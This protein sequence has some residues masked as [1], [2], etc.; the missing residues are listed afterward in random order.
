MF[1]RLFWFFTGAA[2]G[3]WATTK[4]NRAVRRLSPDSL[5]ATAADKA[6]ETGARLRL[7]AQDVRAGMTEREI[8]LKD[9]LGLEAAEGDLPGQRRA[10]LDAPQ[11]LPQQSHPQKSY[12]QS[13]KQSY[14]RKDNH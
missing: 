8:E 3:V 14:N 6:L 12:K 4:V 1:R 5:A 13:H 2:A 10:E 11:P 9:A 7:F